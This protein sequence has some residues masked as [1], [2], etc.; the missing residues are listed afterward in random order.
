MRWRIYNLKDR[1]TEK[2]ETLKY[3]LRSYELSEITWKFTYKS[4]TFHSNKILSCIRHSNHCINNAF[5]GNDVTCTLYIKN[6]KT[7]NRF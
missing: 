5:Y 6:T 1:K 4:D 7:I 2:V 3:I